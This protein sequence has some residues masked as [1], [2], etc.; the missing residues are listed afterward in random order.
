M[1]WNDLSRGSEIF[2]RFEF[3][4][5]TDFNFLTVF[6]LINFVGSVFSCYLHGFWALRLLAPRQLLGV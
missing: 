1:R 3:F 4:I 2:A 5:V 6:G